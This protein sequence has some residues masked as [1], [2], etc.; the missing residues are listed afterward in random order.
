MQLSK[1]AVYIQDLPEK[2][3]QTV[4]KCWDDKDQMSKTANCQILQIT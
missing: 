2:S 3:A 4:S 1:D